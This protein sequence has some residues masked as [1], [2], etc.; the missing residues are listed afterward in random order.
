MTEGATEHLKVAEIL[1]KNTNVSC[2]Y[3]REATSRA[4]INIQ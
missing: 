2:L 1:S 3:S 4:V